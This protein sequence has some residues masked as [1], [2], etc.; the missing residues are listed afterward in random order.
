MHV[1]LH[2]LSVEVREEGTGMQRDEYGNGHPSQ[3][4]D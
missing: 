2:V 1:L 4:M 3:G